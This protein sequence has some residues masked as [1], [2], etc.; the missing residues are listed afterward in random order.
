MDNGHSDKFKCKKC[1]YCARDNNNLKRHDEIMHSFVAIKCLT[2]SIV[3]SDKSSFTEHK[4]QC[5]YSCSYDS[6]EQRFKL[7][8]RLEAHNRMH[9]KELSRYY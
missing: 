9:I 5:F 7:K 3:F 6:C 4:L 8:S 1:N 2:C